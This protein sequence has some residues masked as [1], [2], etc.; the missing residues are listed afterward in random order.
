MI[1]TITPQELIELRRA[2]QKID[3]IDVRTPVEF[4]EVHVDFARNMPLDR[5]DAT[6][7]QNAHQ[8]S[9]DQ[10]LYVICR[11]GSRGQKA[12]EQTHGRRLTAGRECRRWNDCLGSG[13]SASGGR[14]AKAMSLERQVRIAAGSLVLIGLCL[15]TS[16]ILIGSAWLRLWVAGSCSPGSPI[17]AAWACCSCACRGTKSPRVPAS[18]TC[19]LETTSR[20]SW[21]A[22]LCQRSGRLK[23]TAN[24]SYSL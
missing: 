7:L 17:P 3:L 5:L 15:A 8:G 12:C 14:G 6:G 10:P 1:T 2:G 24:S 13:R 19:K 23:S 9:L 18:P 21:L 4:R 11:S 20:A 16:C 22:H